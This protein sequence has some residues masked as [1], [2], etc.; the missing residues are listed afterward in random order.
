[1]SLVQDVEH[2]GR[3]NEMQQKSEARSDNES[4]FLVAVRNLSVAYR[5]SKG[6]IKAVDDVDLTIK[7]AEIHALV[8]E[9][10]CG[11]STL[12]LALSRLLP[13]NQVVYSGRIIYDGLDI[14][15]MKEDE[16]ENVRGTGI[17][18]VFQE[19]MTCLNPVYKVGEQ[20]AESLSVKQQRDELT[21]QR[22]TAS[23]PAKIQLRSKNL[24]EQFSSEI[25][26]LL[27]KVK[28]SNPENV[29]KMYPH[30]LSGG[31]RQRVLIAMSLAQ[32]PSLVVADELTTAV[33][34]TTQAQIL[35]LLR[36]LLEEYGMSVLM[37]T[38]DFGV[39]AA[40]TDQVSVMYAGKI[41]EEAPT[42][43]IFQE[44]LHPYTQGL[45]AS[46]PRGRKDSITLKTIPGNVPQLGRYPTGCRFHPR[47]NKAFERCPAQIPKLIEVSENHRVACFLYGEDA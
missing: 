45:M 28:I 46:F 33:D 7:N 31:M 19:P 47:C 17:S 11:K 3:D 20:I 16:V 4:G 44:P 25:L 23:K 21:D 14:L 41:I 39:V 18:T 37:I 9:S 22:S 26:G 43:E 35:R 12:G 42:R 5:I 24:Y 36:S 32:K 2:L 15:S 27:K 30:E 6:L 10:G 34:V 1:M 40:I 8:G 29:A 38:H 13:E